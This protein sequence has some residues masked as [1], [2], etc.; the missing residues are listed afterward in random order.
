MSTSRGIRLSDQTFQNIRSIHQAIGIHSV[1][2]ND[3]LCQM[4]ELGFLRYHYLPKR[5]R[6][7]RLFGV[8]EKQLPQR[9][10]GFPYCATTKDE[11]WE[12]VRRRKAITLP[13]LR[14][15]YHGEQPFSQQ[16]KEL[17]DEGKVE[18]QQSGFIGD[19]L[20]HPKLVVLSWFSGANSPRPTRKVHPAGE[21]V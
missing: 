4:L 9:N 2:V 7:S 15:K 11:V 16:L 6:R 1:T 19:N 17:C 20:H 10:M 5:T 14:R 8:L 12:I 13:T 3:V 18:I 21:G